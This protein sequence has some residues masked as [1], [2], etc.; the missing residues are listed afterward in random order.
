M[1]HRVK[2]ETLSKL[3]EKDDVGVLGA[4]N[5]DLHDANNKESWEVDQV[6]K[7]EADLIAIET[8]WRKSEYKNQRSHKNL[9]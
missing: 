3:L 8:G 4:P 7:I 6:R 5:V 2:V 9:F 1:V